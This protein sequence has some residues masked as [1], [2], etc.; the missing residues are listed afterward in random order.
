MVGGGGVGVV[1]LFLVMCTTSSSSSSAAPCDWLA[2][3]H[4]WSDPDSGSE[5]E[6]FIASKSLT[7]SSDAARFWTGVF[8]V[9]PPTPPPLSSGVAR[10]SSSVE[11]ADCRLAVDSGTWILSSSPTLDWLARLYFMPSSMSCCCQP[12]GSINWPLGPF[13]HRAA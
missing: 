11:L 7:A 9:T 2:P 10:A 12:D 3:L 6:E 1:W 4:S 5:P 13:T 8:S